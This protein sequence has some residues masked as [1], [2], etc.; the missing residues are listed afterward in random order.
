MRGRPD[1]APVPAPFTAEQIARVR[2]FHRSMPEY[3]PTPLYALP[4]LARQLGV[5]GIY[6][7]DESIRFG[8]NAFK[9]LGASYAMHALGLSAGASVATATDGN[10]GLAVAWAARRIGCHATVFLPAGTIPA[11]SAA[12]RAMGA[13]VVPTAL[14]YDD[15]VRAASDW[16]AAHSAVLIQDT[17][18]DGYTEIP[19][20]IMLGYTTMAEEA[21][22]QLG[23]VH[24]THVFLQAGVGSMAA[25]VTAAFRLRCGADMP[26]ISI[27]EAWDTAC[28]MASV[29]H[30][31]PVALRADQPTAM[32]GLCCGEVSTLA[33]PILQSNAAHFFR[34]C[35]MLAERGMRLAARPLPGDPAVCCGAC[36]AIG[37]GALAAILDGQPLGAREALGLDESTQILLFSTEGN[38]DP[39]HCRA[40]CGEAV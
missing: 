37:L 9:G 8:L 28:V 1:F 5:G 35:D 27:L 25:A 2:S 31:A 34:C 36:G 29:R 17:A 19:S 30:G 13:D 3:A 6:L 20:Q 38:T 33:L 18:F 22:E 26:V 16:A 12:I 21:A 14:C 32:A 40:V 23:A 7:K 24:P 11:R 15:A 39:A 10:H 4:A